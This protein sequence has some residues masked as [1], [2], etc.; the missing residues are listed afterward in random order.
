M[1]LCSCCPL[2]ATAVPVFPVTDE[3]SEDTIQRVPS[4]HCTSQEVAQESEAT[5]NALWGACL[6]Q[7]AQGNNVTKKGTHLT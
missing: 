2:H 7:N 4:S 5:A 3:A 6:F 1:H